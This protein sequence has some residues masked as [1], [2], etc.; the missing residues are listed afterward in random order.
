MASRLQFEEDLNRDPVIIEIETSDDDVMI[1]D[2]IEISDGDSDLEHNNVN[3]LILGRNK[4]KSPKK[5][6]LNHKNLDISHKIIEISDSNKNGD[7][8]TGSELILGQKSLENVVQNIVDDS[9]SST[10][11]KASKTKKRTTELERLGADVSNRSA[12]GEYD[13]YGD[14]YRIFKKYKFRNSGRSSTEDPFSLAV[15]RAD[16]FKDDVLICLICMQ[17]FETQQGLKSHLRYHERV[18]MF[19]CSL[20]SKKFKTNTR[21][22]KHRNVH[23]LKTFSCKLCELNFPSYRNYLLHKYTHMND[24]IFKCLECNAILKWDSFK[25]HVLTHFEK[26]K[27]EKCSLKKSVETD[28]PFPCVECGKIC[29]NRRAYNYH[30][31]KHTGVKKY[32]CLYCGAGF[33]SKKARVIHT[34]SHTG[35]SKFICYVCGYKTNDFED[36][37]RHKGSHLENRGYTCAYCEK[38]YPHKSFLV[39]HMRCH[40]KI[41]YYPCDVYD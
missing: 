29:K 2:N 23:N 31:S 1:N 30:I 25:R 24:E 38:N 36:L 12:S 6:N 4:P 16:Q 40:F 21:L 28:F 22:I 8:H 35:E 34:V 18:Q 3:V 10:D 14:E 11:S 9:Q 17:E 20:C 19:T 27:R 39:N 5:S 41:T 7:V 37:F 26:P 33:R 15:E 13:V 32:Q